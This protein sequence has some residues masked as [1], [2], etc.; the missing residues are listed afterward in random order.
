MCIWM[1]WVIVCE[2][3]SLYVISMFCNCSTLNHLSLKKL[4]NNNK[5]IFYASF[6]IYWCSLLKELRHYNQKLFFF[7]HHKN[8]RKHNRY[9]KPGVFHNK[10]TLYQIKSNTY[11]QK[12]KFAS[13]K[14]YLFCL[15]TSRNAKARKSESNRPK[16]TTR[17]LTLSEEKQPTNL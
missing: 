10:F 5:I 9:F 8:R 15:L 12:T 17:F 7:V 3:V 2:S 13:H 6:K 11:I 1:Q 14:Q 4:N 16:Y